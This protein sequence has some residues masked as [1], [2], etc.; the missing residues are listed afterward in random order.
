MEIKIY[1]CAICKRLAK[2]NI[3]GIERFRSNRQTVRKHLRE[4]H[5]IK[6]MTAHQRAQSSLMKTEGGK[7]TKVT[8][9]ITQETLAV[10][11]N[12]SP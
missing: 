7:K 3:K 11:F 9:R 10:P 8:S 1:E 4:E 2:S 5:G 12:F 6:G